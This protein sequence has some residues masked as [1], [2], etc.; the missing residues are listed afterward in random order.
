MK[1]LS[2]LKWFGAIAFLLVGFLLSGMLAV[3][4]RMTWVGD[5]PSV[6]EGPEFDRIVNLQW[7]V[8]LG[9]FLVSMAVVIGLLVFLL[10]RK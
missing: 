1:R 10:R 6:P 3:Y 9:T 2:A 5:K 8:Q 7:T 4:V